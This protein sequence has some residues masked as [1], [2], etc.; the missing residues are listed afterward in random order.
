MG[1]LEPCDS[2]NETTAIPC[3]LRSVGMISKT[4]R[5]GQFFTPPDVA[6][7]LVRWATGNE[8]DRILDPSCGDGAFIMAH[9]NAVGCEIDPEHAAAARRH[10][11]AALVHG[12]D[13]FLWA[14]ETNER[15]SAIVGNPPFIRYQ[16][17]NGDLRE[18]AL[19]QAA[20]FGADLPALTSSWAPFVAASALLLHPGGR[21][22]F[23]V[24]AEIGHASYAVPLI[25]SLC[26]AFQEV[27]IVA[28]REKIFPTLSEDAWILYADGYGG[29]TDGVRLVAVDRFETA[30][31]V[32]KGGQ[33]VPL[34]ALRN[35]RGRLRRWLLPK[36]A[37]AVYEQLEESPHSRRFGS[38]AQVSIGYVSGAN[39]FFH[40]RSSEARRAGIDERFLM[41]AVRRGG[42]LP[43]SATL[44]PNQVQR[45]ITDD[46]PVLL[47]RLDRDQQRLP[48]AVRRYLD[49]AAGFEAREAYKCRVRDPWWSVPDVSIPDGFLAYMS[50]ETP[51]LV[52][53]GAQ[54]TATN[55]VHVVKMRPGTTFRTVQ[56]AF[57]SALTRLSCEIEGHPLGGGMLKVEPREAQRLLLPAPV[58]HA[59]IEAVASELEYGIT[60]MRKWRGY[61]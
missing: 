28:V 4:K 60:V 54:C 52:R 36:N 20:R 14:D 6:A 41:P 29:S 22:A 16:G 13:F 8:D 11:P 49:T 59:D 2:S 26:A 44:T 30:S 18:R 7:T 43:S 58:M 31:S 46:E 50:G 25:E 51:A 55:S 42:S 47:L 35:V 12:G 5:H 10:A 56:T 61:V 39:N 48:I 45:W 23:V 34:N 19:R 53:N 17:F 38:V 3:N 21:L 40:L 27:V 57:D 9:A 33:H 24:P 1:R 37:L 15:F 32:P